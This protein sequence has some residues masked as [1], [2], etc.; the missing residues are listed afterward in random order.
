MF[1]ETHPTLAIVLYVIGGWLVL[2]AVVLLCFMRL[3]RNMGHCAHDDITFSEVSS[4]K[5]IVR[6]KKCKRKV[7]VD[8]GP[9]TSKPKTIPSFSPIHGKERQG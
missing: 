5:G 4:A 1:L 3:M 9:Y 8:R 6:C 2:C 7:Q